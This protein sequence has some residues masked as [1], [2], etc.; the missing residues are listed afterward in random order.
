MNEPAKKKET[1]QDQWRRRQIA[2]GNCGLCGSPRGESSALCDACLDD[3]QERLRARGQFNAWTPGGRGRPPLNRG[4][5]ATV[6]DQEGQNGGAK[7]LRRRV[8]G[9]SGGAEV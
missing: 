8:H 6:A 1:K 4:K 9:V 2:A 5:I 7:G 3:N